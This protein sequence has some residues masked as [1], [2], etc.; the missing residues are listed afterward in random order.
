[1]NMTEFNNLSFADM[2]KMDFD[3]LKKL[4]SQKATSANK[5][6]DRLSQKKGVSKSAVSEVK[7]SGGRFGVAG[8]DKTQLIG[9]VKRIQAFNRAKSGTVAGARKEAK[10]AIQAVKD[11]GVKIAGAVKKAKKKQKSLKDIHSDITKKAKKIEET[12]GKEVAAKYRKRA[13]A[14]EEAIRQKRKKQREQQKAE[15]KTKPQKSMTENTTL[16]EWEPDFEDEPPFDADVTPEPEEPEPITLDDII[17]DYDD[18]KEKDKEEI[19]K[20]DSNA[21]KSSENSQETYYEQKKK[22]EQQEFMPQ[23]DLGGEWSIAFI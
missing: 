6:L 1:M 5:R 19:N 9:E 20:A 22:Q 2:N 18:M 10:E 8:K 13:R 7:S 14:Q 4:V 11:A 15:R 21:E 12:K 17:K 23:P 16:P 3:S